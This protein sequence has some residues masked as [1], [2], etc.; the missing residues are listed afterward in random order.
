L[1]SFMGTES[2][3]DNLRFTQKILWVLSGSRIDRL[4]RLYGWLTNTLKIKHSVYQSYL[5]YEFN[6]GFTHTPMYTIFKRTYSIQSLNKP[7]KNPDYSVSISEIISSSVLP[8]FKS[9]TIASRSFFIPSF[10][11]WRKA[12]ASL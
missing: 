5:F 12:D 1:R 6:K 9:S 3:Y 8:L 10:L 4:S 7:A 11:A 2:H